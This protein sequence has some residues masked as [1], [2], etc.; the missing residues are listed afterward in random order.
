MGSKNSEAKRDRLVKKMEEKAEVV[1]ARQKPTKRRSSAGLS[2]TAESLP[3]AKSVRRGRDAEVGRDSSASPIVVCSSMP[4]R[5]PKPIKPAVGNITT[6]EVP[7]GSAME[8]WEVNPGTI[9]TVNV[10]SGGH[11]KFPVADIN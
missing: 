2:V 1:M 5:T 4:P 11:G 6:A 7:Y 9:R 3:P 10:N 8:E